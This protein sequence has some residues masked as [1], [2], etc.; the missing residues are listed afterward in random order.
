MSKSTREDGYGR[1][2][3]RERA[4]E[5]E[6]DDVGGNRF[7]TCDTCIHVDRDRVVYTC[8]C[9]YRY[10]WIGIELYI[11]AYACID[12]YAEDV[13]GN[14]F[15]TCAHH[16]YVY[17]FRSRYVHTYV[18]PRAHTHMLDYTARITAGSGW[19]VQGDP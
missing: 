10:V 7:V 9:M 5:R 12:M 6:R 14:R 17:I 4:R 3:E 18:Y 15:V 8:V 16:T 11:C 19:C 2:R 13:G 1:D